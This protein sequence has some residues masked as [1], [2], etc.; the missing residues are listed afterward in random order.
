MHRGG[1]PPSAG[2]R[3]NAGIEGRTRARARRGRRDAARREGTHGGYAALFLPLVLLTDHCA[4]AASTTVLGLSFHDGGPQQDWKMA[5]DDRGAVLRFFI[6]STVALHWAYFLSDEYGGTQMESCKAARERNGGGSGGG[7]HGAT[8]PLGMLV[9]LVGCQLGETVGM[10]ALAGAVHTLN[11][12]LALMLA[13]TALAH[14]CPGN[15][16]E[17]LSTREW[18][19]CAVAALGFGCHP[20]AFALLNPNNK[21]ALQH[22]LGVL[23]GTAL[24]LRA[25]TARLEA[26]W[27]WDNAHSA[28]SPGPLCSFASSLLLASSLVCPCHLVGTGRGSPRGGPRAAARSLLAWRGRNERM[29]LHRLLCGRRP[30]IRLCIACCRTPVRGGAVAWLQLR[31][32]R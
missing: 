7:W 17:D 27:C 22:G 12:Y 13:A 31:R 8:G 1:A 2:S 14:L 16:T 21:F 20:V 3:R 26:H 23:C 19:S 28:V 6:V 24:V 32:R 30:G 18:R 10:L 25:I 11:T 5:H 9:T 29:G 15:S 4:L